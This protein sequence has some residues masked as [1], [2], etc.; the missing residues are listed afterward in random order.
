MA[1][2]MRRG[3]VV[4]ATLVAF[5]ALVGCKKAPKPNPHVYPV[6]GQSKFLPKVVR[7]E[8]GNRAVVTSSNETIN[9]DGKTRKYLLL[10]PKQIPQGKKLSLVFLFHGDGGDAVGFHEGYPFETATGRDAV[11]AYL[12]CKERR[13]DLESTSQNPDVDFVDQLIDA[14]AK[15]FPIDRSRVY[16]TGYSSGGFFSNL[17]ACQR[18]DKVRAIA[19]NAGGAPYKQASEWPNGFTKCPGEAPVATLALHG[20]E[21]GSV[22]LDSGRF[23]AEYWAYVN[24][25]RL[26]EEETTGY[27]QCVSYRGCNPGK[28]VAWCVI[29]GLDHWVWDHAAEATWTFFEHVA[30]PQ[31]V[32]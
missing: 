9:V 14:L 16:L 20:T 4:A 17:Y 19:S 23:S 1:G 15:R 30:Q 5:V 6:E 27:D 26:E 28:D 11:L 2:A 7:N 18:S 3:L 13:W 12:D 22:S 29:P 10:Q 25:C 21:D 31:P 24:G 8:A 32:R